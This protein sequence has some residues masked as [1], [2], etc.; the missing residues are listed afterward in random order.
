MFRTI[1]L[2]CSFRM[3]DRPDMRTIPFILILGAMCTTQACTG[4]PS[5]A[6]H[7]APDQLPVTTAQKDLSGLSKAWFASGCFWCVEEVY[8]SVEGV[9]EAIS[10]YSGGPE[11]NPT[12]EQVSS[13]RTG[14]AETVEVYYDPEVVSFETLVK[15]FFESHDPTT[16]NGQGPDAGTQYRSIAFYRTAEEKAIIEKTIA[17]LNASEQYDAP[18]VTEVKAF[19]QFWPAEDY[20]QNYVRQNPDER[21]VRGVSIPRFERFKKAMPEVLK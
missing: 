10:G 8:E 11:P 7:H 9:E 19:E 12:Y 16:M 5:S 17:E 18:V 4:G 21:Y 14:H 15:V 3:N 1:R 20:H 6:E 2:S 13:G